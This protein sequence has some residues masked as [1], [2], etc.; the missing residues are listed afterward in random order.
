[1][2]TSRFSALAFMLLGSLGSIICAL[3]IVIMV[4]VG[5]RLHQ[6]NTALF[7]RIDGF[8]ILA[9]DS[10]RDAQQV[11]D[12]SKQTV[13]SLT[14]GVNAIARSEARQEISNRLQ[15]DEKTARVSEAFQQADQWLEGALAASDDIQELLELGQTLGLSTDPSRL[16]RLETELTE[17]R[18]RLAEAIEQVHGVRQWVV[19]SIDERAETRRDAKPAVELML[20]VV[21]TLSDVDTR[22]GST[23]EKLSKLQP[24]MDRLGLKLQ[25]W[26]TAATIIV[27]LLIGWMGLGQWFVCAH[28]LKR[29]RQD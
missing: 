6:T 3:A 2:T 10:V 27:C 19:P 18:A 21:A 5:F 4:F 22:L 14:E 15:F 11:L 23:M 24:R 29:Y 9:N 26:I 16:A 13:E 28:G 1:M 12:Q 7:A 8:M 17:M 25:R 20:K